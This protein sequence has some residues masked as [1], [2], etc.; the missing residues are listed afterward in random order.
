[1]YFIVKWIDIKKKMYTYT[2]FITLIIKKKIY[3]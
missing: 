1:M 3:F 2:Y